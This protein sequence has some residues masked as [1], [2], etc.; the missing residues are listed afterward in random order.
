MLSGLWHTL[1]DFV[2]HV[3]NPDVVWRNPAAKPD[4][5][6]TGLRVASYNIMLGG[7]KIEEVEAALLAQKPD[8]VLIQE[9]SDESARRLAQKLGLHMTY[10]GSRFHPRGKAILSRFPITKAEEIA[11]PGQGFLDRVG[12]FVEE[13]KRKGNPIKSIEPL[14]QRTILHAQVKVGGKAVDLLDV[15]QSLAMT[16]GNT[17]QLGYL[18]DLSK[19]W[20]AE[21]RVVIAGGDFNTNF[22]FGK[23]AK[24]D[25]KG[26]YTTVTDT[27]REFADRYDGWT[28]GNAADPAN[29]AAID[30]L[31]ATMQDYWTAPNRTVL[32]DGEAITPEQAREALKTLT[33]GTPAF[34]EMLLAADGASHKGARKRFDNVLVSHNARVTAATID[35]S[36]TGSDHQ[37][38]YADVA[39]G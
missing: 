18:A 24:T 27:P 28:A 1:T 34:R 37:P 33:P 11:P 9:A 17:A 26:V 35:H 38:V 7:Q 31:K 16:D 3:W 23:A 19:K 30:R 5:K 21:G 13:W 10:M 36:A 22:N 39:L 6:A 32:K 4:P 14:Q 25:A 20:E 12:K 29:L 15:H 8:V 2:A